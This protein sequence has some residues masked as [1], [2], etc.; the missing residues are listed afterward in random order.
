MLDAVEV[1]LDLDP[2][3]VA[4]LGSA[5]GRMHAVQ[6][7]PRLTRAGGSPGPGPV[8]PRAGQLDVDPAGHRLQR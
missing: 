3:H 1:A 4:H 6:R 2:Q 8:I 5:G 7:A